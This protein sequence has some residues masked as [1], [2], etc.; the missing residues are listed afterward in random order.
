MMKKVEKTVSL[1]MCGKVKGKKTMESNE[2]KKTQR[3]RERETKIERVRK[4]GENRE[5]D[6][7]GS[8]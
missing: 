8:R 2:R 5:R 1:K 6:K 4:G 3:E 7:A